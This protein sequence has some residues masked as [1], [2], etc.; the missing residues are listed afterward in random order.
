MFTVERS[1]VSDWGERKNTKAG[2]N[3]KSTEAALKN[4]EQVLTNSPRIN[5]HPLPN[6]TI[7]L[8]QIIHSSLRPT[9]LRNDSCHFLSEGGYVL[10]VGGEEEEGSG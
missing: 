10:R 8:L 1:R 6:N 5:P 9:L 3:Q 2:D 7:Q 4:K